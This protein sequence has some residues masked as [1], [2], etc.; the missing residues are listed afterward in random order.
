M[1]RITPEKILSLLPQTQCKKCG[2]GSCR[3]YADAITKGAPINCCPTGGEKNI[4]QL[5]R[6]TKKPFVS[7][8]PI[9]GNEQPHH[10]V[11][12][13]ESLCV[14][15]E[16][17]IQVCPVDAIIGAKGLAHSVLVQQC[18]GCDL[19]IKACP[20]DCIMTKDTTNNPAVKSTWSALSAFRAKT[21]YGKRQNRLERQEKKRMQAI[22]KKENATKR[23]NMIAAALEKARMKI[24]KEK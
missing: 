2:Y 9:Y 19:C 3:D 12:I 17:C 21:N 1:N 24:Q 16:L 11:A 22:S 10:I 15:C 18:T 7:L 6:L 4:K 13:D 20:V 8:N 14:G 23:K 5:S